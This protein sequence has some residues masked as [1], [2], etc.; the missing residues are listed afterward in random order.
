MLKIETIMSETQFGK[1]SIDVSLLL[2][3]AL[4]LSSVIFNSQAWRNLTEKNFTQLQSLQLRLLRKLVDVPQSISSSFL[5]LELGVL[6]IKYEIHQRQI[7]FLHHITNLNEDDPVYMLYENMKR[8]PSERNWLND[9]TSSAETYGIDISENTLKTISKDAFKQKVK[10]AIQDF[11]FAFLKRECEAQSKTKCISYNRFGKQPYLSKLYPNQAKLVLKCRAKCVKI[12]DHRPFQFSNIMCRW[13]HLE[14]ETLE[15]IVN[16]GWE[17]SK[18][19][20]FDVRNLD[21]VDSGVEA[22]LVSLATR[23]AFFLDLVDY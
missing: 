16:C 22:T 21:N 5:F 8:L 7:T 17:G 11:V 2:Y 3:R 14:E 20:E 10:A 6:P 13:C 4:F 15:H 9:I 12:K 19:F 1:H 18:D 23:V